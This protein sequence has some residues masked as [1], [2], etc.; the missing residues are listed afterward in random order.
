MSL[1]PELHKAIFAV[2][3]LYLRSYRVQSYICCGE[4][5]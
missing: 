5:S 4:F 1:Y 2:A 3:K